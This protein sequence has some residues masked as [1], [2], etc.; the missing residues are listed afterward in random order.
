MLSGLGSAA[1]LR[2]SSGP[3]EVAI[4]FYRVQHSI[5][6]LSSCRPASGRLRCGRLLAYCLVPPSLAGLPRRAGLAVAQAPSHSSVRQSRELCARCFRV[7]QGRARAWLCCR[8]S[9][10]V[11]RAFQR[12][13]GSSDPFISVMHA[14]ARRLTAPTNCCS[15]RAAIRFGCFTEPCTGR[16]VGEAAQQAVHGLLGSVRRGPGLAAAWLAVAGNPSR[17]GAE[18]FY[19]G[20]MVSKPDSR[21]H[22]STLWQQASPGVSRG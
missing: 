1:V 9:L 5:V 17:A 13:S 8:P 19:F 12:L 22:S 14:P 18:E 7:P 2:P 21:G 10:Q 20:F 4:G 15:G 16:S 6:T 11:A 3:G